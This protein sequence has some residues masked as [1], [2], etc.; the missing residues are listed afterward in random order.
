MTT[1]PR[2]DIYHHFVG[3]PPIPPGPD[4]PGLISQLKE[5]I[6]A[7][8]DN[9]ET[10]VAEN[11]DVTQSAIVLLGNLKTA[12]DEA[13]ASGNMTKV[14]ELADK[15]DATSTALAQAVAANTPAA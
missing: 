9:L 1:P 4:I 15:L 10:E 5:E 6:M 13:I 14:Q 11:T 7:A 3:I 2:I 8:I 12:L